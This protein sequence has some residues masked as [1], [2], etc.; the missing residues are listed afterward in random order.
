[1]PAPRAASDVLI[2]LERV[3]VALNGQRVLHNLSWVLRRG[4]HWAVLGANGAGKSTFLRLLRGEVWPAPVDGGSRHYYFDGRPTASP[5]G[6]PQR[7]ALVS[8][9]QQQRYL[10]LHA[11]R[12][13]QPMRAGDVV[14]TGLLGSE[15]VTRRPTRAEQARVAQ[16]MDALN[17]R[18]LADAPIDRLSQGQLRKVLIARALIGNPDILILDEVGVGLDVSSRRELLEAV[19]RTVAQGIQLLITTHRRDEIIPAVTHVLELKAGRIAWL[20]QREDLPAP[21][22]RKAEQLGWQTL[23]AAAIDQRATAP[24]PFLLNIIKASVA[25]AEGNALILRDVTWRVNPGEHWAI[26]GDNGAGKSTLL[27]LILGEL[28]PAHGGTIERF[29]DQLHPRLSSVWEVKQRIGYVS[30]EFQARYH[31]D[32]TAAQVVA[33]GFF[34]SVGW[35]QPLSQAQKQRVQEMLGLFGLLPLAQRSILEMS[36]GQARKVLIARALVNAPRLLILDEVFDGLDA[37]ARAGLAEVLQQAALQASVLMVTH[38][39]EDI[40]P[41]IT[42]RLI[43][44]GGHIASQECRRPMVVRRNVRRKSDPCSIPIAS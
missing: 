28:W 20:G 11:R 21:S 39:S 13:G 17:I 34:A 44:D 6:V 31:A 16:T 41:F 18:A 10:R 29:V 25:D 36:Y 35:L 43:I 24:P 30:C 33:T 14:F 7:M 8:A 23:D 27:R 42:H 40:L 37:E 4:E 12:E 19:Q 2:R 1:M 9:E 38:H 15:L 5:I 26:L 22:G 3:N 32:L